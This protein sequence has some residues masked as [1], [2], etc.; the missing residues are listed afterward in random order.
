MFENLAL[1]GIKQQGYPDIKTIL[2]FHEDVLSRFSILAAKMGFKRLVY[3]LI[4]GICP[5]IIIS[6]Y[7]DYQA[8][9]AVKNSP[10]NFGIALDVQV[11]SLNAHEVN[12]QPAVLE[13][14]V[15]WITEA[16]K[17]QLFNRA[18]FYPQRNTIHLDIADKEWMDTYAGTPFW[19]KWNS[20][21]HGFYVLSEAIDYAS[22]LV[23]ASTRGT[24]V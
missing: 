4:N 17:G 21:Y 13:R 8:D 10:H 6:G 24:L 2:D 1:Q 19:V 5:D 11:S 14:Q 23:K 20:K 18:G 7:R 3:K 9:S 15:A 16:T 12:N 22:V